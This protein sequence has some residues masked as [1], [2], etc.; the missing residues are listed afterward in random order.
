M[1]TTVVLSREAAKA[2]E[3]MPSNVRALIRSKLE[4]L[5]SDPRALANNIKALK[6]SDASRLRVGSWR[7]LFTVEPGRI[8]VLDIGSRGSIYR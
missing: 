4:L 2:L 8:R 6:A 5:A 7:I 3:R 1:A